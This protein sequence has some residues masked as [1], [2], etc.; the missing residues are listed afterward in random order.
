ML[1]I[2]PIFLIILM[3]L[4]L[5]IGLLMGHPIAFILG[6]LAVIFGFI[7]WGPAI[8]PMFAS[9]IFGLMN[10]FL[11][12]AVPM[13]ILMATFLQRSGIADKL[14]E[15]SR[16]L[17]GPMKG[18]VAMA[19]IAVSTVFAACTGVVGASI[20]ATGMVA[21]PAM[22]KYGYSKSLSAGV[23]CAG[24]SLGI[25]IPPSIMLLLIADQTGLSVGRLFIGSLVPGLLLAVLYL[26]YVAV[27][28]RI[29]PKMG[30]AISVEESAKM[31]LK[32]ALVMGLTSLIPPCILVIGVLGSIFSGMATPT[33]ASGVGA[34]LAFLMTIAYRRFN[35]QMLKDAIITTGKTT[36]MVMFVLVGATC[37]AGVFTGIG[38]GRALAELILGLGLDRWGIF[39]TMM[40]I[41]FL[42]GKFLDY[43]AI[44]FIIFPI[45]LPIALELG[46][47]P[48][49]F[50]IILAINLQT[51]LMTPPV[52]L[53][54]FY[55]K[56]V[57][58]NSLTT[59]DIY[60]GVVPFILIV[61]VALFIC[62]LFPGL[63][64]T[65]AALID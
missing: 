23:I 40:L 56:G 47:D 7:G 11:L 49:W 63:I 62:I 32:K 12:V 58:G 13:F 5:L 52:G 29:R 50:A 37:F 35:W 57:A 26:I 10:S 6:G 51:S 30:P 22:L 34:I 1:D 20:V 42:L 45:L 25:I 17:M 18:G 59:V 54:L 9:R 19:V 31:P 21:L 43:I 53:A 46:F 64:L 24:G 15:S 27:I 14:F 65:P 55:L 39:L 28:C 48:L 41:V 33:E 38:G 3:F 8:F 61:F 2:E 16:Y 4:G 44:I 36:A 60:K